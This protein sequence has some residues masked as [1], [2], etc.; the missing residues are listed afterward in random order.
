MRLPVADSPCR[1]GEIL[2]RQQSG[3]L[4]FLAFGRSLAILNDEFIPH[5]C[6]KRIFLH[7]SIMFIKD[8]EVMLRS[9]RISLH[10]FLIVL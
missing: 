10:R 8:S 6:L 2:N 4:S 1:S 7:L 3:Q 9:K 5:I